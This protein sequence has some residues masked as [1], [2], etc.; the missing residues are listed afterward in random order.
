MKEICE[1]HFGMIEDMRCQCDVD[2][3]LVDMLTIVMCGVLCG[4]DKP[5]DIAAYGKEKLPFLKEH[6]DITKSP[7]ESTLTRILN[8]VNGDAV[9]ECVVNIMLE[10]L[11]L[12]GDIIAVDGKTICSTAKKNSNREKLHK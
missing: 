5:E 3:K 6:F 7:S 1:K 10:K 2:H 4:L 8:M 9:A 11:D 12:S